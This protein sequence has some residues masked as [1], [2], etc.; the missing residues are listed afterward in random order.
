MK[1]SNKTSFLIS[2][3]LILALS[4]LYVLLIFIGFKGA[5]VNLNK[6]DILSGIVE[7]RGIDFRYDSR[8]RRAKVFFVKLEGENKKLGVYRTFR[9]YGNLLNNIHIGD[10][11]KVYY[12]DNNNL[13]ENV[14]I[15]LIQI[16]KEKIIILS[17]N[18]YKQK[19]IGL[20]VLGFFGVIFNL[21][22]LY[23]SWKKYKKLSRS[24]KLF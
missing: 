7:D 15:D 2:T 3:I 17:K 12:Y 16:E 24:L 5:I 19:K 13:T 23:R 10:S 11:I 21:I 8:H 9:N 18:E 20:I 6:V 14:N 4:A 22:L 1:I